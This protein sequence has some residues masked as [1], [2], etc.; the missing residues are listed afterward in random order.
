MLKNVYF[1]GMKNFDYTSVLTGGK[2]AVAGIVDRL[3]SR[4]SQTVE[5]LSY[6]P[7]LALAYAFATNCPI[8]GNI[9]CKIG[10]NF[11]KSLKDRA[12]FRESTPPAIS[13]A[14][15]TSE[16]AWVFKLLEGL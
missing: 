5:Y 9:G 11:Y 10:C 7:K 1:C 16:H 13:P 2:V 14:N 12:Y 8:D 6:N 3:T 4:S 15:N